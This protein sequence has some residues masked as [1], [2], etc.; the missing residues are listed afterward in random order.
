MKVGGFVLFGLNFLSPWS[1]ASDFLLD[2]VRMVW[3]PQ[4][5][6]QNLI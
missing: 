1:M 6:D 4:I 2:T 3:P 5:P